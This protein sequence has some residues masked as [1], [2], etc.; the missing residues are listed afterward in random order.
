MRAVVWPKVRPRP[1][2]TPDT[3][4]RWLNFWNRDDVIAARPILES[5]VLAS[6]V[7]VLPCS[8]RVDSDGLWSS[9]PDAAGPHRPS[10]PGAGLAKLRRYGR[11]AFRR[12]RASTAQRP[13][14]RT[15]SRGTDSPRAV[16]DPRY[17][18]APRPARARPPGRPG[19]VL[20]G[21][22]GRLAERRR[23]ALALRDF[24]WLVATLRSGPPPGLFRIGW[25]RR[26]PS[27]NEFFVHHEDVRR[28][29]GRGPRTNEPA[30]DEALWRNVSRAPWFLARRLRG[31]GLELLGGNRSD[32][33]GPAG[34]T[35]RPYRRTSGRAA[36]L[37]LRPAG[38]GPCRGE[39][40]RRGGP[41]RA[42][43]AVRHVTVT[44]VTR[45]SSNR[46]RLHSLTE[47]LSPAEPHPSRAPASRYAAIAN[48]DIRPQSSQTG[49]LEI[50]LG[51]PHGFC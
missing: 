7:G 22:W 24:A 50:A 51:S 47:W 8:I 18:R 3:V 44:A 43:R 26:L 33:P 1:P 29:N 42:T 14:R 28:A 25:V 13:A 11:S 20:P 35:H 49:K 39:R 31:A 17:G 34:R 23:R 5:D 37:P 19:L 6:A 48:P 40:A 21:A 15:R 38:R 41:S 4:V 16:D 27:L 30:M 10:K 46:M 2:T 45:F 32:R 12:R 9:M 36:A